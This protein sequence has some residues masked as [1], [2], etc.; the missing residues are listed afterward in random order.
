MWDI[1]CVRVRY[2]S[3]I[4]SVKKRCLLYV[5]GSGKRVRVLGDLSSSEC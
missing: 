1:G 5:P 2:V 4:Y 3:G